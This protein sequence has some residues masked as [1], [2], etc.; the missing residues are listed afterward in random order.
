LQIAPVNLEQGN[1]GAWVA[2][3]VAGGNA[4]IARQNHLNVTILGKPLVR[5]DDKPGAPNEA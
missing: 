1:G 3:H 5:G 4:L 2:P